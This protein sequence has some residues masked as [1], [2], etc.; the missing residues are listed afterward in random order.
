MSDRNENHYT[1]PIPVPRRWALDAGYLGRRAH[2]V[3]GLLEIDVTEAR[4]L[5]RRHEHKN[6]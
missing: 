2:I 1:E 4:T 5:I 3:H 6:R